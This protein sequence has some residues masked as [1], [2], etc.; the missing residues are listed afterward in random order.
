V[1]ASLAGHPDAPRRTRTLIGFAAAA[2]VGAGLAGGWAVTGLGWGRP[3][4]N[5]TVAGLAIALAAANGF[6]KAY[7][8]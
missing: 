7:S 2:A 3:A 4:A 8:P 1:T 6:G 5:V